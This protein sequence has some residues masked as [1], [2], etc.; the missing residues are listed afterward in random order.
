[1]KKELLHKIQKEFIYIGISFIFFVAVFKIIFYNDSFFTAARL[2]ASLFWA[3]AIPG[4]FI[5]LYWNERLELKER[6]VIGIAVAAAITGITS[7]YLG[8]IGINIKWHGAMLPLIISAVGIWFGFGKG[9]G[10]AD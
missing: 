7:Y 9:R 6:F 8:L 4:Y 1:M 5:M 3:F 2:V 10:Q